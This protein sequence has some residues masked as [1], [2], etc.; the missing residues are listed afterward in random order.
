[1]NKRL[2]WREIRFFSCYNR[3]H[4]QYPR[5][6]PNY[7]LLTPQSGHRLN[8]LRRLSDCFHRLCLLFQQVFQ[9]DL[10]W[11]SFSVFLLVWLARLHCLLSVPCRHRNEKIVKF[12]G[13]LQ[14]YFLIGLTYLF[15]PFHSSVLIPGFDLELS[16]TERCSEINAIRC[17]QILLTVESFFQ[18]NQLGVLILRFFFLLSIGV[19]LTIWF[20]LK[21]VK[22]HYLWKPFEF[23]GIFYDVWVYWKDLLNS[24]VHSIHFLDTLVFVVR[25]DDDDDDDDRS[26]HES[27]FPYSMLRTIFWIT[28]LSRCV[29]FY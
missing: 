16:Q 1:M 21:L 10:V 7:L 28:G 6:N 3:L 2:I 12:F 20:F 15:L 5:P 19:N 13:F 9:T 14:V 17:R 26:N 8:H 24:F 18:S 27:Y 22:M 23:Y 25:D 11:N 4:W 29:R